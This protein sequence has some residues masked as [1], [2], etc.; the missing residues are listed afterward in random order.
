MSEEKARSDAQALALALGITFYVVRSD[1]GHFSAVQPP[2]AE[3]EIIDAIAP[4][5]EQR[6]L[7]VERGFGEASPQD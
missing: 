2:P 1:D 6:S 7:D 5:A 3:S 4:P